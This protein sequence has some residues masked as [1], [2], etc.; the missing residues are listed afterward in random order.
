M[1]VPVPGRN[2][3]APGWLSLAFRVLN[4]GT[5]QTAGLTVDALVASFD[6]GPI[7]QAPPSFD[8]GSTD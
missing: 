6:S 5:V 3:H 4:R 7:D 1:Q 2:V 8:D